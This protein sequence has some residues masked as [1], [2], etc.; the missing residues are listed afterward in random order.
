M[1]SNQCTPYIAIR[2]KIT[3]FWHKRWCCPMFTARKRSLRHS[4]VFTCVC[5][6]V[7]GGGGCMP[8]MPPC[9]THPPTMHPL[10]CMLPHHACPPA[11]HAPHHARPP[12][13]AHPPPCTHDM[14]NE[15]VVHILLEC[16]LVWI[17]DPLSKYQFVS[18]IRT[19][20]SSATVN[21]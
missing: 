10:S 1:Y 20:L 2:C 4:N 5:H 3:I 13:H 12:C 16:I 14:V 21:E 7:H 19:S 8:C 9:H 15:Q 11:M 6:S 18:Y 17:D